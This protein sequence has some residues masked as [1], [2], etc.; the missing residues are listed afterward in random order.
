M[1][2]VPPLAVVTVTSTL[3]GRDVLGRFVVGEKR[4][5]EVPDEFRVNDVVSTPPKDTYIAPPKL[6]PD[7]VT[8]VA[9]WA[10]PVLGDTE[11]TTGAYVKSSA[12]EVVGWEVPAEFSTLTTTVPVPDGETA[13]I[14]VSLT[15]LNFELFADPNKTPVA[16]VNP[17]PVI[18]TVV[19]PSALPFDGLSPV[20]TGV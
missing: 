1:A 2:E 7:M 9:P 14:L 12:V 10:G 17:L 18:V 6:L 15:T 4:V 3:L 8:L 20:I 13:V 16:P 11:V 5:I 19:P